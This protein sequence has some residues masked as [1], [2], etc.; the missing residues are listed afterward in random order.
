MEGNPAYGVPAWDAS[1]V[2]MALVGRKLG[3]GARRGG[4]GAR[5]GGGNEECQGEQFGNC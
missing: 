3:G 1:W 5:L 2:E 4:P